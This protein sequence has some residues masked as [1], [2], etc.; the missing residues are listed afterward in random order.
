[1]IGTST[2]IQGRG[3]TEVTHDLTAN[4]RQAILEAM[5]AARG[6]IDAKVELDVDIEEVA[7]ELVAEAQEMIEGPRTDW[8]QVAAVL[9]MAANRDAMVEPLAVVV[10][11]FLAAWVSDAWR[12]VEGVR[13]DA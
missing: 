6:E 12:L 1:M 7:M 13:S 3:L 9:R 4:D 11:G 8:Y 10:E 5:A 2:N